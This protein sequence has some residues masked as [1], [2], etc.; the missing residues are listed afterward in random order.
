MGQRDD[1]KGLFRPMSIRTRRLSFHALVI[2]GYSFLTI[3][4][5]YPLVLHLSTH[6]P[7]HYP[8]PGFGDPWV[9][10]WGLGFIHRMV[11]ESEHWSLFTD[12]IFYP[13]GVDLTFPLVFGFGLPLVVSIPFVHFLGIILTYNLF[14]VGSFILSSYATFRLVKYL[15]GDSYSAWISGMIFGFSPYF[16]VRSLTHLN[17]LANGMWIPLY[18]L[19]FIK[20]MR[21][22]RVVNMIL[23][24]FIFSLT[25]VSN[26]YYAFFL[27][28][29]TI[30]Y[31][32]FYL[33]FT[34]VTTEK[35]LLLKRLFSIACVIS[36]FLLPLAWL[37]FTHDRP[38]VTIDVP[39]RNFL[40]I[41]QTFWLFL[42][43]VYCIPFGVIL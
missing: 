11:M 39:K 21:N 31:V 5:T 29:F 28:I 33:R 15:T 27:G 43:R 19:F 13:R 18:I 12:S 26:F 4:L 30:L 32:L 9:N 17:L 3:V 40:N 23:A 7:G 37:I 35:E 6:I 41:V 20:S 34:M 24:S 38:D 25:V 14:I 2:S 8:D 36:L 10:M 1:F 42:Y 22:G 16:L